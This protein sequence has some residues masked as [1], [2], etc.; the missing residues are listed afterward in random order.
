VDEIKHHL[1]LEQ[2]DLDFS[3]FDDNYD[4]DVHVSESQMK[5]SSALNTHKFKDALG[6]NDEDLNKLV[7]FMDY[8]NDSEMKQLLNLNDEEDLDC[9]VEY[10]D[11]EEDNNNQAVEASINTQNNIYQNSNNGNSGKINNVNQNKQQNNGYNY[12]RKHLNNTNAAFNKNNGGR[13]A[14]DRINRLAGNK[15]YNKYNNS[16]NSN[17]GNMKNINHNIQNNTNKNNK[18]F[19]NTNNNEQNISYDNCNNNNKGMIKN[20]N[21]NIQYNKGINND[22]NQ[23]GGI[24]KNIHNNKAL[25]SNNNKNIQ[26][27]SINGNVADVVKNNINN[28]RRNNYNNAHASNFNNNNYI[29]NNV[30]NNGYREANMNRSNNSSNQATVMPAPTMVQREYRQLNELQ[31]TIY[32]GPLNNRGMLCQFSFC[33]YSV[34][35]LYLCLGTEEY[36]LF[37]RNRSMNSGYHAIRNNSY[38]DAMGAWVA[39]N[40]G[41][42]VT[43]PERSD[44]GQFH[45]YMPRY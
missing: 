17:V 9:F 29:Q 38:S 5:D 11:F 21:N 16:N 20:I 19:C 7:T 27:N 24:V 1:G 26:R 22:N 31:E 18:L 34:P 23:N 30:F 45:V 35:M 10:F 36:G 14:N 12:R 33:V 43:R 41:Q 40:K 15:Q 2:E 13:K 6:M 4:E 39:D 32:R 44:V 28:D 25:R 8:D 42:S 3:W 37:A